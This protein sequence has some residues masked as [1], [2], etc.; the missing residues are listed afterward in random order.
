MVPHCEKASVANGSSQV[1]DV[2]VLV[3]SQP[4]DRLPST[5]PVGCRAAIVRWDLIEVGAAAKVNEHR[6]SLRSF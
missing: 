5:R 6:T 2:S 4:V 3:S 1:D